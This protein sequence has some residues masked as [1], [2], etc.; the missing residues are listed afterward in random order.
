[1]RLAVSSLGAARA[2]RARLRR[3]QLAVALG[4]A[5]LS[6]A[7]WGAAAGSAGAA[8]LTFVTLAAHAAWS[9]REGERWPARAAL[10]YL[11]GGAWAALDLI[12]RYRLP[13]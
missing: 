7:G 3:R 4:L 10:S 13:H 1:M 11:V 5:G 12:L 9:A 6:A 8:V 2:R